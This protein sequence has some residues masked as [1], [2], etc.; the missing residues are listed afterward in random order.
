MTC[1]WN[2]ILSKVKQNDLRTMLG[3]SQFT[4][5]G[6]VASMKQA[7]TKTS[8]VKW[9]GQRVSE[10][11]LSEN[12]QWIQEHRANSIR[13][14]YDC[15]IADPYLFLLCY[16]CQISIRHSYLGHLISYDPPNAPRYTVHF[17]SNRGHIQ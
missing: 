7:N 9:Q 15:G 4:P 17:T 16:T 2:A 11:Q 8:G 14:G 13:N 3:V 5:S 1:F 6:L 12:I 10:Q